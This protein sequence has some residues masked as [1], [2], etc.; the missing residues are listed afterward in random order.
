MDFKQTLEKLKKEVDAELQEYL[1]QAIKDVERQ[2]K[3]AGRMLR[4]VAKIIMSGGKRI[5]PILM[6]MGYVAAGGKDKKK[7]V[8]ASVGIELIHNFFLVHDDIM[9]HGQTRHG[10]ETVH[11]LYEKNS[12]TIFPDCEESSHF[13]NSMAI[14]AGD[15]LEVLGN[16]AILRSGFDSKLKTKAISE[17]QLTIANTIV[18]QVQ[19]VCIENKKQTSEKEVLA[20]YKNKTAK[21]TIE[22]PLKI[23]AILAGADAK[24]L[25]KIS[26]SAL[27]IGLAFQLQDDILGL[28]GVSEKIGKNSGADI[29]EGKKTLLVIKAFDKAEIEDVKFMKKMLGNAKITGLEIE[30]FKSI[31]E[32]TGALKYNQNLAAKF[33]KK[34]KIEIEKIKINKV[35]KDFL[36]EL[37]DYI[38]KRSI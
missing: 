24:F 2:D 30:K 26:L 11:N 35:A 14:M 12:T 9:D 5:R 6:Y 28:F 13:G 20:M 7:I 27:P 8:K 18:G 10:V 22:N 1:S 16:Q 21:Y 31:I 15:L 29:K 25:E 4:H 3:E 17:L 38:I 32:K 19:D 36:L 23:G 33:I 34:G 37:A